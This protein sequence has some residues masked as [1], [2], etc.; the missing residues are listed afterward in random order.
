MDVQ[1]AKKTPLWQDARVLSVVAL[2]VLLGTAL[3]GH[4]T[5]SSAG[6][7][8]SKNDVWFGTAETGT[9]NLEVQGFGKLKSKHQRL[10]TS[11]TSGIVEEILLK[12]G[13]EVAPDDV[14]LRLLNPDLAQQANNE[15]L[16]L[17][18]EQANL[19]QVKL[20][21]QRELLAQQAHIT[22]L[23][24]KYGT[25]NFNLAATTNLAQKGI[26]SQLDHKRAQLETSQLKRRLEIENQ[27]LNQ[28]QDVHQESINIQQEKISQQESKLTAVE[29]K[30]SQLIIRANMA[31]VLQRL[32]VELGQSVPVG[33]ILAFV[34]G[35]DRLIAEINVPQNQVEQIRI[36]QPVNISTR[37]NV[38]K[39][40]VTRID[41]V[42]TD[43]TVLVEVDLIGNLPSGARPDLSVDAIINA[44]VLE[45]V[46]FIER[47]VNVQ[48][49]ST[50]TL[51]RLNH[52]QDIAHSVQITF[53][54]E[55]GR[56]IQV[57]RG[58]LEGERFVL[59]DT[60]RWQQFESVIIN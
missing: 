9:L 48:P 20:N 28:L 16:L 45:N 25:A 6:Q 36:G 35:T 4:K 59:S 47:P 10:I 11:P 21:N 15:R 1:R 54:A 13:A 34:G 5:L 30:Q 52:N 19:R 37:Q 14:I 33:E 56:H 44:G 22:E 24:A 53:G 41:P 50:S 40:K 17:R 7:K 26:V 39:G 46:L 49:G 23:E 43:G 31:G 55:A 57:I 51:Y 8:I 18:T 3:V 60:S 42:V 27:R 12:P 38:S 32:D 58:A 2:T 29:A